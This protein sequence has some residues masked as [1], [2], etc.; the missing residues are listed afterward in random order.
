M[1]DASDTLRCAFLL[2]RVLHDAKS[3]HVSHWANL[4]KNFPRQIHTKSLSTL[5]SDCY[6]GKSASLSSERSRRIDGPGI[7]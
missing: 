3:S 2:E 4:G 1:L 7:A 5:S 6:C